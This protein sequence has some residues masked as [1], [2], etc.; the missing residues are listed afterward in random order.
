MFN[1]EARPLFSFFFFLLPAGE[2]H[3]GEHGVVFLLFSSTVRLQKFR[4]C[5]DA[6][7]ANLFHVGEV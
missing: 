6:A 4:D 3:P 1:I 2:S 5:H 7:V